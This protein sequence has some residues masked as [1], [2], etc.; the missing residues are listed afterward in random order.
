M[1]HGKGFTNPVREI[2]HRSFG[3]VL[4]DDELAPAVRDVLEDHIDTYNEL[5]TEHF[6]PHNRL[7]RLLVVPPCLR[8][9]PKSGK[10][11]TKRELKKYRY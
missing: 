11:K 8:R 7:L 1:V 6:V 5:V 2:L 3:S 9:C 4:T 10:V